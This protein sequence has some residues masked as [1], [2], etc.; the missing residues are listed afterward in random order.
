MRDLREGLVKVENRHQF[1]S[2]IHTI[3]RALEL[4]V[5]GDS[6]ESSHCL[7][8]FLG[9][10]GPAPRS[11]NVTAAYRALKRYSGGCHAFWKMV[12]GYFG[13]VGLPNIPLDGNGAAV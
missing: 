13:A 5:E 1:K 11:A 4:R 8:G 7:C 3:R 6:Y 12:P 10:C 9:L 2:D